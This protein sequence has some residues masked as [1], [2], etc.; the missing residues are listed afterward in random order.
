MIRSTSS[1]QTP[2]AYVRHLTRAI[3]AAVVVGLAA[4]AVVSLLVIDM[5]RKDRAGALWHIAFD[6]AVGLGLAAIIVWLARRTIAQMEIT[7][8]ALRRSEERLE[9]IL[10]NSLDL[11]CEIDARAVFRY[12]SPSSR[13]ILGYDP[14][15]LIGRSLLEYIHPDD[16]VSVQFDRQPMLQQGPN[17]SRLELRARHADGRHLWIDFSSQF[18]LDAQQQ[19]AGAVLILRDITNRKQTED[20]LA[21]Y[22]RSMRALVETTLEINIQPDLATL[23]QAIVQRACDLLS[24]EMGG[25]YLIN[26]DD[27]TLVLVAS[28]P[29]EQVGM[30]LQRGEGLA[31]R[32]VQSGLPLF[33]ADYSSWPDRAVPFY[34]TRLGRTLGVPL[35]LREN[36][37]GVLSVED[38]EPGQFTEEDV[39]LASLFADQAAIAIENR[40]LYEQSQREL[41]V[42]RQ[43]EEAL[44]RS[45]QRYR[46]LI[47][48]QGEGICFVDERENMTFANPAANEIFGMISGSLEGHNLSEFIPP[49]EFASILRE[50]EIRRSG[51]TSTY[52][53]RIIRPDGE[54]RA[55]LVTARPRFDDTGTFLGTFSIFRDV[56]ERK[57]AEEELARTRANL[58]RSNR[59]L[60]QVLEAGNLLRMNLE[61]DVVLHEIVASAHRALGYNMV[62][63]NLLDEATQRMIVHSYAGLDQAGQEI[64]AGGVYDWE[65]ERRLLRDEFRLGCAYFV[66]SGALDW[67]HEISGPMYVPDLPISDRPD[68]WNPDDVLFIPIVLRDGRI[69]GTLWLD[70]P[71]DGNR[72]TIE[73]LRPLEIFVNQA[74]IAIENAHLFEAERQRRRELEAVYSAS[75]QLTQS[76][77]PAVVLDAILNSVMQLVPA[78]SVQ[79]FLYDGKHLQFGSGLWEPG[80]KMAWPSLEPRPQGLTYTVARQGEPLFVEDTAVHP[81]FH[82]TSTLPVP[83]LAIAGLPLKMKD[84]VLGVMNICY[85][86]PHQFGEAERSLLSLLAAQAAI[87]LH[88]AWL[89]KEVQSYAAELERRVAERTAELDHERQHLQAVLDSAGEGIQIM[90]SDGRIVYA[91]PAT[92]RITGYSPAETIGQT[93]R[94]WDETVTSAGRLS[95]LRDQV[96]TGHAWQGEIINRRKD[97]TLYDA[98]VTITPLKDK[99]QQVTGLVVVHRDITRLKELDHLK[100]QFVSRIG[101]ELRTPIANIK[102]YAQLLQHGKPDKQHDYLLTLQREVDR[103]T[104]LNDSFLEIAELDAGR[105]TAQLSSVD[106]NQ[107]LKDLLRNFDAAAQQRNLT[108]R[109]QLDP[110]LTGSPV[111]T[112]RAMLARAMSSILDN[113]LH[114]APRDATVTVTTSRSDNEEAP[115]V[116]IAVHNTGPGISSAELPHMF[117]RF[118]RGEAARDYKVPGAG[119]GLAI[120][121]AIVQR[122]N[123]RLTADSQ[124]GQGVTFTL[125]LK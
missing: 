28:V 61:L 115:G 109:S 71:Q 38:A 15:Q 7:E 6:V 11:I 41:L 63:L 94:L 124:P 35:N 17:S 120:A 54:L 39:R 8:Q 5:W 47:E 105:T 48:N 119:L 111:T 19:V 40:Q 106:L 78:T 76:L 32:V 84:T 107:L 116:A 91:N 80:Q 44:R 81:V 113:A 96:L 13:T 25:L 101:H 89:H 24:A 51:R 77:D 70:A 79:L 26:Q 110:L 58:E 90:S 85:A 68:A 60:T 10:D 36:I 67:N 49:E 4:S 59:Q 16:V 56:T 2:S 46:K 95:K 45:E 18:V 9:R 118:Y 14:E 121:Q 100:D 34:S 75:W 65:E 103:L 87:A 57:Q 122:L 64:L 22:A 29:A 93:T 43:A 112:D 86:A 42:R 83:M 23:L 114:Y 12:V 30:V 73:S 50:T 92:E 3:V 31:G 21:R 108:L 52:E 33:I 117:E 104:H 98:S 20:T 88:N 27:S 1:S 69:A 37:I 72:P 55:L 62:V 97:G 74:A 82:A 123:G 66:P 53:T 102:L 125:W 99:H